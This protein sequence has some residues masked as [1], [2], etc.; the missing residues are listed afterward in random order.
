VQYNSNIIYL[1]AYPGT[2]KYTI[3]KELEKYGYII[4]DNQLV[5][6]PVFALVGYKGNSEVK[7]SEEAWNAISKIRNGVFDFIIESPKDKNYVFTN[8]LLNDQGDH[9]LYEQVLN[10]SVKRFSNFFP[11]KFHVSESEHAQR[12][13]HISRKDRYKSV[14]LADMERHKPLLEIKHPNLLEIDVTRISTKDVALKI[15]E[16][17]SEH[18]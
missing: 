14:D 12:I 1:I 4:C 5:N 13:T 15:M 3:A 10:I 18:D 17:V 9:K 2:G 6:N 8:V 11:V 16:F 7:I